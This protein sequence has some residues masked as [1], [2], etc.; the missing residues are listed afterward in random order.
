VAPD[1]GLKTRRYAEI[2]PSLRHMVEAARQL[3]EELAPAPA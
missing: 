1:C 2:E 3:R